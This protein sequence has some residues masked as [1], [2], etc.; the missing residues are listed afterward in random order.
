MLVHKP[1]DIPTRFG[2]ESELPSCSRETIPNQLANLVCTLLKTFPN[3][4]KLGVALCAMHGPSIEVI[5]QYVEYFRIILL[6]YHSFLI[7]EKRIIFTSKEKADVM[8]EYTSR[9]HL[10]VKFKVEQIQ[11]IFQKFDILKISSFYS[12]AILSLFKNVFKKVISRSVK[13]D[14][15]SLSHKSLKHYMEL[16]SIFSNPFIKYFIHLF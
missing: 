15:V 16:H 11:N 6:N 13:Y 14:L 5:R 8:V 4:E 3:S 9:S 7:T 10:K 12:I 2:T 1:I